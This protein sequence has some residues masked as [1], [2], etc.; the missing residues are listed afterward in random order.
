MTSFLQMPRTNP[1]RMRTTGASARYTPPSSTASGARQRRN[2]SGNGMDMA[3][4]LGA[5]D[6]F[7]QGQQQPEQP[8]ILMQPAGPQDGLINA[9][10]FA[11]VTGVVGPAMEIGG[12]K[13]QQAMVSPDQAQALADSLDKMKSAEEAK[14]LALRRQAGAAGRPAP[15]QAPMGMMMR[16]PR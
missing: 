11:P 5:A 6:M 3:G 9:G 4:I 14:R 15:S 13:P 8:G 2:V 1:G 7:M 16:G 10:N 12:S